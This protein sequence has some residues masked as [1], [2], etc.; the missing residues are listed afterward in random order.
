[1]SKRSINILLI[2]VCLNIYVIFIIYFKQLFELLCNKSDGFNTKADKAVNKALKAWQSRV[3]YLCKQKKTTILRRWKDFALE[4]KKTIPDEI[5]KA[6]SKPLSKSGS[7]HT[8]RKA[9][10]GVVP[11]VQSEALV[12]INDTS[13]IVSN[14]PLVPETIGTADSAP[15]NTASNTSIASHAINVPGNRLSSD[16]QSSQNRFR[17]ASGA[18]LPAQLVYPQRQFRLGNNLGSLAIV[19]GNPELTVGKIESIDDDEDSKLVSFTKADG[20]LAYQLI[21]KILYPETLD[22][23]TN[24]KPCT[25]ID[26]I[27]IED[28]DTNNDTNGHSLAQVIIIYMILCLR[29]PFLIIYSTCYI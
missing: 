25:Q 6:L 23:K 9:K 13:G 11:D 24:L 27:E 12:P 7:V 3:Q 10:S 17:V 22:D 14:N 15:A 1:M 26:D 20:K 21:F 29:L 5:K 2:I 28:I 19:P 16:S 4:H 8:P 18:R